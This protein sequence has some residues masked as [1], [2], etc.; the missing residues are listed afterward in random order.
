[1]IRLVRILVDGNNLMF[2]LAE[3]AVDAG[4]GGVGMLLADYAQ[5][6]CMAVTVVFDGP[7]PKAGMRA[8]KRAGG[9]GVVSAYYSGRRTADEVIGDLIDSHTAPR[10][11]TVV[12]GD[13][14]VQKRAKRRRCKVMESLAFARVLKSRPEVKES[15]EPPAKQQGLPEGQLEEWLKEF[16][17]TDKTDFRW[18]Y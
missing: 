5:R 14:A 1:M 18:E 10:R 3:L 13:R 12:S 17:L 2:A 11:L 4:R 6:E 8:A 15:G 7:A 9:L 16:G